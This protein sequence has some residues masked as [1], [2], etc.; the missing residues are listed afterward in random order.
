M[1]LHSAARH[2]DS[3]A[4]NGTSLREGM[5]HMDADLPLLGDTAR[6]AAIIDAGTTDAIS[7]GQNRGT[8]HPIPDTAA[9]EAGWAMLPGSIH[10]AE[11]RRL[12]ERLLADPSV[13]AG[14]FPGLTVQRLRAL[15]EPGH[16]SLAAEVLVWL[17][18]AG[19]LEAPASAAE[20]FRHPRALRSTDPEQIVAQLARTLITRHIDTATGEAA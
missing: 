20:P 9:G 15:L 3:P 8:D 1:T 4:E 17:D 7:T 11:L 10:P 16:R 6:L 18:Q 14:P 19:L 5:V 13:A 12:I 2:P